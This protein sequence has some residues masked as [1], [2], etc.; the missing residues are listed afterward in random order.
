MGLLSYL[1][2][3]DPV[4]S[5]NGESR[6][7]TPS[8]A[9]ESLLPYPVTAP[10]TVGESTVLRVAEAWAVLGIGCLVTSSSRAGWRA[11]RLGA[12]AR[13]GLEA[14]REVSRWL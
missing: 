4:E 12:R 7:P 11:L 3:T 10:L 13:A 2:G 6:T 5:T 9:R 1:R 8:T 14:R